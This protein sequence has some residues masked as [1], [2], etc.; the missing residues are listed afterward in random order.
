MR[1]W[2]RGLGERSMSMFNVRPL[3]L[4]LSACLAAALAGTTFGFAADSL[5][6]G[7]G[8]M[9][10]PRLGYPTALFEQP[11]AGFALACVDAE[12]VK[13]ALASVNSA[14]LLIGLLGLFLVY[15]CLLVSISQLWLQANRTTDKRR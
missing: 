2:A 10:C 14:A 7:I 13:H 4:G 3:G 5:M 11:E 1:R 12:G 15:M 8:G 6:I 9:L